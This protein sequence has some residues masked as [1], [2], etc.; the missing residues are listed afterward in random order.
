MSGEREREREKRIRITRLICCR[1]QNMN[2]VQENAL[3]LIATLFC[4]KGYSNR[5]P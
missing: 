1:F 2:A 4:G 5:Y 3:K